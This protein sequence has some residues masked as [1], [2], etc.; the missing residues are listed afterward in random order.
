M[1]ITVVSLIFV[2]INFRGLNS[3][4]I[5]VSSK[6]KFVANHPI[7]T[8]P[9]RIWFFNE[10]WISWINF[11]KTST[12][13]GFLRLIIKP[14]SS[15][16]DDHLRKRVLSNTNQRSGQ[17]SGWF[18]KLA[19]WWSERREP[20]AG[21]GPQCTLRS[22]CPSSARR[23]SWRHQSKVSLLGGDHCRKR[24]KYEL[25]CRHSRLKLIFKRDW[26]LFRHRN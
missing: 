3:V 24:K 2:C 21:R 13:I 22:C 11:T 20:W 12:K 18:Q 8:I 23:C 15:S 1:T 7:N 9:L 16:P 4:K 10:N 25:Q 19:W 14:P 26:L 17:L 5:T 6:R